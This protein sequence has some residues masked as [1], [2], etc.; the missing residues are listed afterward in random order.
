VAREKAYEEEYEDPPPDPLFGNAQGSAG[1][2]P[3]ADLLLDMASAVIKLNI[4]LQEA[5][6]DEFKA[7]TGRLGV[8]RGLVDNLPTSP[9][10]RRAVGFRVAKKI[11]V[12]K[13]RV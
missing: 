11:T 3:L 7:V 1:I 5:E 13:G 2:T 4:L 8:F 12:K 6:D 9:R 10:A